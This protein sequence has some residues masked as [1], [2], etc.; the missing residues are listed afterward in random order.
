MLAALDR[1]RTGDGYRLGKDEQG[2]GQ[3]G[4]RQYPDIL[5]GETGGG[6]RRQRGRQGPDE[7]DGRRLP[8][9]EFGKS[10]GDNTADQHRKDHVGHSGPKMPDDDPGDQG[11][12]ADCNHVGVEIVPL[13][14]HP[15]QGLMQ[16]A[17]A[18]N[19]DPEKMLQLT[20]GDDDRGPGRE[21]GHHRMGNE[22]DDR[23][24]PSQPHHQLDQAD[25]DRKG[26]GQLDVISAPRFGIL[27]QRRKKND[28]GRGG[29]SRNQMPGGTEQGGNHGRDHP[30]IE[31]VLGRHP[32]DDGKS[33]PLR[34]G[35]D[36]PGK[37]GQQVI[38]EGFPVYPRPPL[39]KWK[40]VSSPVNVVLYFARIIHI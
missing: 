7:L 38:P 32:S 19:A 30:G 26:Q 12:Q 34:Q 24:E 14:E 29:W 35:D 8:A 3:G 1:Q 28:G 11:Y 23:T 18:R 20:G 36:R 4:R 2:R 22:I 39:Q 16:M 15:Y 33:H 27:A 21:A 10:V 40:K 5:Q 25:H 6:K 31:P 13:A 17:T 9:A 37:A